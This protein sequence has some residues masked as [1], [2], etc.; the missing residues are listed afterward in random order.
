[1][2]RTTVIV[3]TPAALATSARR[4][5]RRSPLLAAADAV[6]GLRFLA[7]GT[8]GGFLLTGGR[9]SSKEPV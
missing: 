9:E 3:D 6:R 5:R 7:A 1:M 2:T 8:I 4:V